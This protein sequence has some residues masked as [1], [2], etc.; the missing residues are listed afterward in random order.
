MR[1]DWVDID[2]T[3]LGNDRNARRKDAMKWLTS[4]ATAAV[5]FTMSD[6]GHAQIVEKKAM[7]LAAAKQVIA[8]AAAEAKRANAPG[9]VIAVVDDGGNLVA[10]ERL[11]NTFPAGANIAIGKARTA[12]MFKRPTRFFEDVVNKGRTTMV[13]LPDFTPLQGGIPIAVDG[14]VIGGVGVSGA[15]SAQQDEE[16]AM[17]G[18]RAVKSV[19][20]KAGPTDVSHIDSAKTAAAFAKGMPLLE[21]D[22]YKIH[23]S[24]RDA[25]GVAE[26]HDWETD[27]IYV[28]DGAA[29][30]VTGGSVV[31]GKV[32][33]PGQIR[34]PEILNGVSRRLVKGDVMVIPEGV[35]HWFKEVQGPFLYFVVKPISANGVGK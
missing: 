11:D 17:A 2:R 9:G 4:I 20:A 10:L 26:I 31:D 12:A 27:V 35:P 18:A 32:T 19:L 28:L 22:G 16:M 14:Q 5:L 33:E 7:T 30:L 3:D 8:A 24:R 6:P 1:T 23:A 13:A 25:P 34:G 21:V 15:A 29:T